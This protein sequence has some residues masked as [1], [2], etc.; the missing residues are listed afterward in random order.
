LD[1]ATARSTSKI[2]RVH[3]CLASLHT[4]KLSQLLQKH[5]RLEKE[6]PVGHFLLAGRWL[7]ATGCWVF[8]V[9]CWSKTQDVDPWRII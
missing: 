3:D 7:L 4:L 2:L 1:A 5:V 6:L 8:P 9:G